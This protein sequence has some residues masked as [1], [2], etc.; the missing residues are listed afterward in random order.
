MQH[1]AKRCKQYIILADPQPDSGRL[2][3][4]FIRWAPRL[5]KQSHQIS[6]S[7]DQQKAR[8]TDVPPGQNIPVHNVDK[9]VMAHTVVC[10]VDV[11]H[12]RDSQ[13]TEVV[14]QHP[15]L[16]GRVADSDA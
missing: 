8:D 3:L 16:G 13:R 15:G 1:L 2:A 10:R 6:N 12:I 14:T 11:A 4:D 9:S 5:S 7:I